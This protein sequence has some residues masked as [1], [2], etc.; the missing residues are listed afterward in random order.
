MMIQNEFDKENKYKLY[1]NVYEILHPTI[2]KKNI[3]DYKI[4]VSDEVIPLR[5]FYPVKVTN[6]EKV[7]IYI[8]GDSNTT[9]C[10]E[11]YANISENFA[12]DLNS[13][14]ISLDYDNKKSQ[15]EIK[16]DLINSI[17]FL[18]E[19]FKLLDINDISLLGD[20][21]GSN[22][23][24]EINDELEKEKI[25]IKKE[26]LFYPIINKKSIIK[27]LNKNTLIIVGLKDINILE[28]QEI[29]NKIKETNNVLE[30]KNCTHGFLKNNSKTI[31]D[32]YISW[33]NEYE[34]K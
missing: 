3:S 17:K 4:I 21:T 24:I 19:K 6:M 31:K 11:K 1:R 15:K 26:I 18:Y 34:V 2:S 9:N 20:S 27:Q 8:H 14:V 12:I 29:Y 16:K 13:L 33:I 23:I 30:Y 28:N 5:V 22:L 32:K 25:M 10:K 7:I